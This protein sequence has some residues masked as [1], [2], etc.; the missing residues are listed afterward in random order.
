MEF[1]RGSLSEQ[2]VKVMQGRI[3]S[4]EYS[5]GA[6]LPTELELIGEFGVS[7]TVIREAIANLK[8]G[9][10]VTTR[11][12]VGVFVQQSAP[13]RPFFIDNVDFNVV[14]EAVSILE[15]RIALE[16]EAAAMAADRR[17]TESLAAMT[18]AMDAMAAAIRAGED[19]IQSDLALHRAIAGATGNV[20]FLKLFN[21]LGEL[22]VPRARVNMFALA[23][24]SREDYLNRVNAEHGRVVDAIEARDSESA[25]SAM[26]LH[27]IGSKERLLRGAKRQG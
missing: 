7:R 3:H 2:I 4:G 10:L 16:V 18:H 9:G 19:A 26:R 20:H 22:S 23:Q 25:R 11:Q 15:L 1:R 13:L 21:Y 12:G 6:K 14:A 5:R 17:D 27:L 24:E 8:A